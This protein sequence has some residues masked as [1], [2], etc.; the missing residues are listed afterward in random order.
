MAAMSNLRHYTTSRENAMACKTG[1]T[2][3]HAHLGLS[4]KSHAIK[5]LVAYNWGNLEPLDLDGLET[6]QQKV[7]AVTPTYS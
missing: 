5:V 7:N 2:Q 4:E 3:Y 6:A 1:P